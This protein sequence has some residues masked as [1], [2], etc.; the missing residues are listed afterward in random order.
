MVLVL[1]CFYCPFQ[2]SGVKWNLFSFSI[3]IYIMGNLGLVVFNELLSVWQDESEHL[4][5]EWRK[6]EPQTAV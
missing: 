1:I 4:P 6:A 5:Q 2:I 3:C